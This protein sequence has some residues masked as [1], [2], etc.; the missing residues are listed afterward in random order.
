MSDK[1]KAQAKRKP[2]A[3]PNKAKAAKNPS[4]SSMPVIKISGN[5]GLHKRNVHQG[6]YDF[7]RLVKALPELAKYVTKNPNGEATIRFDDPVAV[8]L[9]NKALLAEHYS[10]TQWDI[11]EGYLCPPIPGRADY[12]HRV[13]ELLTNEAPRLNHKLVRALDIGVGANCIYPIVGATQYGWSYIGSDVDADSVN[14]A[15]HIAQANSVLN[16]QVECRLQDNSQHFFKGIIKPGEFYDVT[17]CNPPFHASLQ[18]AQQGTE[19]KLSNLNAHKAKRGQLG[20]D[21]TAPAKTTST[22]LNFGGQKAELWCPGGEATFVKNMALESREFAE[23]VL[24][25][26]TLLSKKDNVRWLCKNLE[27]AGAKQAVVVEM[28]QGQKISRFVAWSFKD[29]AQRAKW[30]SLKSK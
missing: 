2:R 21:R 7:F 22:T 27:K 26:T 18:E 13:A 12:I 6:R 10:V 24:W 9:L 28:S 3:K 11:P 19:R 20:V 25:F 15:N 14:N 23:Q 1:E 29:K 4:P 30:L 8:K 16:G 5:A 17:T